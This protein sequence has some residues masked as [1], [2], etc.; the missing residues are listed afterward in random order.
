M[1][2]SNV[3]S[4]YQDHNVNYYTEEKLDGDNVYLRQNNQF[5]LHI[6]YL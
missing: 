6:L 1:K 4:S 2:F 5:V 3:I